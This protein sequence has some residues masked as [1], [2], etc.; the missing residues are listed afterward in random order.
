MKGYYPGLDES[1]HAGYPLNP[2]PYEQ[3]SICLHIQIAEV[4]KK[5][6]FEDELREEQ[7]AKKREEEERAKRQQA[8]RERAKLFGGH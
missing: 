7:E 8:F 5:S 1:P 4:G 6:R 3:N 2:Y